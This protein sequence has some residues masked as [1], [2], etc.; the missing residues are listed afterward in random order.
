MAKRTTYHV[1]G[2]RGDW[3][4]KRSGAGR[5]ASAHDKKADAVADAKSRAKSAPKGQV[6][7]HNSNGRIQTEYT[8]GFD[9]NPPK[10]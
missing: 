4:V 9:P 1:T 7:V 2:S 3:K 5:A 8:Y 10:G 6:V